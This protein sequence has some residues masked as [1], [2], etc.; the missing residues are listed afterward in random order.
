MR[1]K[2]KGWCE[3]K[4]EEGGWL[5]DSALFFFLLRRMT[6][7]EFWRIGGRRIKGKSKMKL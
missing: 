7:L 5:R 3:E 2:N 4:K 6:G 1:E